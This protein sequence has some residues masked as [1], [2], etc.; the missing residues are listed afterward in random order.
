MTAPKERKRER[1]PKWAQDELDSL[2]RSVKWW[3]A[4][5]TLGPEDSDTFVW[6][7]DPDGSG[8][9]PLGR[10]ETIAFQFGDRWE[11]RFLVHLDGETLDVTGG[12]GMSV[13][14]RSWNH[15]NLR[16]ER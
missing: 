6:R 10:G 16:I 1:L 14:P 11:Q 2:E 13:Q 7:Y 3:K 12:N 8:N 5:A 4:L 15:V 9:K